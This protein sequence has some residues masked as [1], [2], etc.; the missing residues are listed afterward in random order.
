M[1]VCA[2]ACACVSVAN[3]IVKRPV[4]PLYVEDGTVEMSFTII[5]ILIIIII[6][7]N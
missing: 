5:I 6:I 4:L 1:C 3:A 2:R 7:I